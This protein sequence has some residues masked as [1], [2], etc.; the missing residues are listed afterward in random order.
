[1]RFRGKSIRRKIVALLLVPLVSLTAVWGFATVLTG[2]EV[3]RL[4]SV[5]DIVQDVGYPTEDAARGLQQERRQT[6]V[7][8]ADPR[9]ADAL[10]ALHRTRTAT[11]RS[12]AEVR[13]HS[14]EKDVRE[15]MDGDDG[16]RLTEVLDAFDG[17]AALRRGVE[18]RTVS[19]AQAFDRYNRL[20]D[21]CYTLLASLDGVDDVEMD[22]QARALVNLTRARELLSRE[23]ALLGSA[24]VVGKVSRD[25]SRD[26]SDLVAQRGL[27]YDISLP[28][29]PASERDRYERFWESAVTAP[30][31]AAEQSVTGTGA[32]TPRPVTAQSWDSAAAS[33]LD[34]LGALDDQA[35]DRFQDRMR[36]IGRA[37]V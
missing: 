8:L 36:Q 28:L 9:A 20:I 33:V 22:K 31:L 2:R 15:G 29:L 30:L 13:R 5:T 16:E 37:H 4:F 10:S 7:Y 11:D 3:T 25:E 24:L 14:R 27:L 26:V 12:L 19:R 1:M 35:G 18:T 34:D 6:L 23:D 32:G 21:P 17:L